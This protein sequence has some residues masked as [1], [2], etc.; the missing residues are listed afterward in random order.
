MIQRRGV[1]QSGGQVQVLATGSATDEF[2]SQGGGKCLGT[3][4]ALP[5]KLP[6]FPLR[7]PCPVLVLFVGPAELRP[8][9]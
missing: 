9:L 8:R 7:P 1:R 4:I 5:G 6:A 2:L 3:S